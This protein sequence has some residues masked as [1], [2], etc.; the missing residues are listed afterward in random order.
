MIVRV[1]AVLR[2]LPVTRPSQLKPSSLLVLR[3]A[4]NIHQY[5][6]NQH[7]PSTKQDAIMFYRWPTIKHFRLLSRGKLYQVVLMAFFL[8]PA[9]ISYQQGTLPGSTLTAAYVAAGGTFTVLL[10]LSHLFT[11][12]IGEMAYLPDTHQVCMST[13]TFLGDRRDILVDPTHILPLGG[14]GLMQRLEIV[15]HGIFV[16]SVRYGQ[17]LNA[18]LMAR[19]IL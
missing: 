12:V 18:E 1:I 15:G 8:P 5:L 14:R 10:S 3:A 17:V 2:W 11:R 19:L 9:T 16:Y 6:P 7:S 4:S 13:L